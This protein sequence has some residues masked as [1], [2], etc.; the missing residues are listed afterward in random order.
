MRPVGSRNKATPE[1]RRT[2]L[3]AALVELLERGID[4][5]HLDQI[6]ARAGVSKG[7]LYH[8]F[9]SKE[10]LVVALYAEAIAAIHAGV[11]GALGQAGAARVGV[12]SLV[13][14]YLRWFAEHPAEGS[15]VWR[16]MGSEPMAEH[17]SHVR[18]LERRFV[19][20]VLAWLAPSVARG[21]V[22]ALPAPLMVALVIGPSRDFVRS[23]LGR[24]DKA[25]MRLAQEVLPR[26][27]WRAIAAPA[28]GA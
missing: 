20:Q 14:A 26:E 8:H 28:R 22:V 1:R 9:E 16:V 19:E 5:A 7:S 4:G 27:A 3:D 10:A 15:F 12:E 23:W 17:I 24:R 25:S 11:E 18:E 13:E 6:C 2:I 21:E